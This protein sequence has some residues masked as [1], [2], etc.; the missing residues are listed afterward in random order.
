MD[1]QSQA[2]VDLLKPYFGDS[3]ELFIHELV[4]FSRS[5]FTMETW[6]GVVQYDEVDSTEA[7]TIRLMNCGE[8]SGSRDGVR[9]SK[10]HVT[11][12]TL[13]RQEYS[14]SRS[15]TDR[16]LQQCESGSHS[17]KSATYTEQQQEK[18]PSNQSTAPHALAKNS[19][20]TESQGSLSNTFSIV[21]FSKAK[22]Q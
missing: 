16:Q 10:S 20:S 14:K 8:G 9:D 21:G 11:K 13:G 1:I 2:A 12:E 17:L 6:D 7:S 19:I 22:K 3:T 5:P 4:S 18:P 15:P